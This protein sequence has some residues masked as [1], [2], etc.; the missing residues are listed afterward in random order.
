MT[1]VTAPDSRADFLQVV[2]IF[3]R[4]DAEMRTAIASRASWVR[5]PAGEWLMR[6]G[7]AGDSLYVVRSGRLE[8]LLEHPREEALRV[9]TRGAVVGELAVMTGSPRSAS[10]RARRDSELLKLE[11]GEFV[12]LLKEHPDFSFALALELG[13][14]LQLSRG[15]PML[16][17]ALPATV[18]VLPVG[19]GCEFER[20]SDELVRELSR[21][22]RVESLRPEGL[23]ERSYTAA[24]DRCE[25]DNELVVLPADPEHA[26]E[27][28]IEFCFR[29][30][31][32]TL[33]VCGPDARNAPIARDRRL[34]G[35]VLVSLVKGSP[36]PDAAAVIDS[37]A[38]RTHRPLASG[39]TFSA[40]VAAIARRLAGR[41]LGIVLSGGGAR[42]FAH[43]GVLDELRSAGVTIDRVAGCSMGAFVGAMFAADM[44]AREM[45]E[46][47]RREFVQRNPLSDYTVPT[48][49]LVRG[50][51]AEAMLRRTFDERAIEWLPREFFCVTCDL[52]SG[53]LVI[54]RRGLLYE[55][56]GA[57]MCLPGIFPPVGTGGRLLVDGGVLNNLP[58]EPMAA[59]AE[60]PVIASDVTAQF[61]VTATSGRARRATGGW[62]GRRIA[63]RGAGTVPLPSLKDTL[64]RSITI[65]SVDAVSAA[66]K[67]ADLLIEPETAGVGMLEFREIDRVVAAGRRAAL[68]ALEE[69]GER[70]LVA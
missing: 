53:E 10:V 7:E 26:P 49:S 25:R 18:A 12:P 58:V 37:I 23:D 61:Q 62:V 63:P 69:A 50:N 68:A 20:F 33:A 70:F 28:W 45:V 48:V 2:P 57:S 65:G 8:I 64:T 17:D 47:C 39:D 55:A 52:M 34:Q 14:Q 11:R 36:T 54:H 41:A 9:L 43:I 56:V 32:R 1:S 4:L 16:A 59:T 21:L 51:R 22:K 13:H 44:P 67:R 46:R 6:Q 60:G 31:D 3:A 29:Q 15:L 40:G 5:V 30:A 42:G 24:L 19:S 66:R 27:S 35:C 38:P